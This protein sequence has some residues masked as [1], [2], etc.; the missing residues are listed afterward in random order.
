MKFAQKALLGIALVGLA[1]SLALAQDCPAIYAISGNCPP[2]TSA[3]P[4]KAA[5]PASKLTPM[6]LRVRGIGVRMTHEQVV[7]AAKVAGMVVRVDTQ[8]RMQLTDPAASGTATG[9]ASASGGKGL[10]LDITFQN[11]V[12]SQ[13][14]VREQADTSGYVE[15][16]LIKKWG[17]PKATSSGNDIWG[18][19][20]DVYASC[21]HAIGYYGTVT[22]YINDAKS[23]QRNAQPPRQGVP[24]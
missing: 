13:I 9:G 7:A 21:N 8:Q 23:A 18:N 19:M 15:Q 17:T 16:D 14:G 4:P 5:S 10:V 12:S 11:G 1:T 3:N 20:D 6:Q 2:G 22:V 24:M